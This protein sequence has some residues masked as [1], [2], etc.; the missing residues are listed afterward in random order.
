MLK[1][2]V[3]QEQK[4]YIATIKPELTQRQ[5]VLLSSFY[6]LSQERSLDQGV[7]LS[8]KDKDIIYYQEINGSHSFPDDLFMMAI[9]EIDSE[10][11]E[12]KIEE[13]RRKANKG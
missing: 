11:I 2:C 12:Q 9:R 10:Y 4:D 8:I 7:P 13:I 3:T 1:S 5:A 6:R